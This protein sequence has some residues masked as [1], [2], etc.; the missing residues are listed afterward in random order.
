MSTSQ[1]DTQRVMVELQHSVP[2]A[3][4]ANVVALSTGRHVVWLTVDGTQHRGALS[5]A[6][7]YVIATAAESAH[8]M[9]GEQ[10]QKH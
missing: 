1:T 9:V 5:A 7:S 10:L 3:A 4:M 2:G 8:F 6:A